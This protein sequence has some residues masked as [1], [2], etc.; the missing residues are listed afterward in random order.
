MKVFSGRFY[1]YTCDFCI[2]KTIPIGV[3]DT[4]AEPTVNT[5]LHFVFANVAVSKIRHRLLFHP[6]KEKGKEQKKKHFFKSL[7]T[8]DRL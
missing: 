6:T 4:V 3:C 8:G 1:W 5:S 7:S 2:L